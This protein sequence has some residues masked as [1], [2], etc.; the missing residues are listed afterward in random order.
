MLPSGW[1][2]GRSRLMERL[3]LLLGLLRKVRA[4]RGGRGSRRWPLLWSVR[5][6]LGR[7]RARA[8]P[9]VRR[10]AL[11]NSLTLTPRSLGRSKIKVPSVASSWV[12]PTCAVSSTSSGSHRRR[13]SVF[14][15]VC[16]GCFSLSML[17]VC[18]WNVRG[19]NDLG[20]RYLV[21]SVV[22]RL[23]AS[24]LCLQETKVFEF[25]RTF[26]SSFAGNFIDKRHFISAV[27]ASGG[28]FTG[29]NSRFFTCI[30]VLVRNFSLTLRLKHHPSG[31]LFYI[32]NVYG[33]PGREGKEDF[34]V[35]L[36]S[37]KRDCR[38]PWIVCGDFNLT[39][40]QNERR[41]RCWSRNLTLLFSKLINELELVDLPICNQQFTWSNLHSSP[42]LAKLD[43]FLISTKW[44]SHFPK[45]YVTALHRITSDHSP[46]LLNTNFNSPPR[47]F[48]FEKV[49]L[50][51]E[52]FISLIPVWWNELNGSGT[53]VLVFPAK[54]HHCRN[55][56]RKWCT[57][58]FYNI[59][60]TKRALSEELHQ[61][62]ILEEVQNLTNN[63]LER[64]SRLK[65]QLKSIIRDEEIM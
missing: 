9:I 2:S 55:R 50:T 60:S 12:K 37:L 39:R 40:N 59:S 35:E 54:L 53:S 7:A 46:L 1:R 38:G 5:L 44:D 62:D 20:K 33:P 15:C 29:W 61:L 41:G 27:G 64:W 58:N 65:T 14:D 56:I 16:A 34:C 28:I 26:T 21:K 23:K 3:E 42:T 32:T 19:L 8:L 13:F 6:L 17:Q 47:M 31:S 52:D 49:W 43:R 24:V 36:A 10:R 18:C 48:R 22:S 25:S 4:L 11:D 57:T 51:R 63:Q 30:E 45:S